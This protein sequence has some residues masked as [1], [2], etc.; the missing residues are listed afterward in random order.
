M[1]TPQRPAKI[2]HNWDKIAR[3]LCNFVCIDGTSTYRHSSFLCS[4]KGVELVQAVYSLNDAP[5]GCSLPSKLWLPNS[6]GPAGKG[7]GQAWLLSVVCGPVGA[8]PFPKSAATLLNPSVAHQTR[9]KVLPMHRGVASPVR[10]GC[11]WAN[12]MAAN[13]TNPG[14]A[15][16]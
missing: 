2:P 7:P 5:Q 1:R 9:K 6:F 13:G 10:K 3:S 4:T 16:G 11:R 8:T 14:R 15:R 12:Q